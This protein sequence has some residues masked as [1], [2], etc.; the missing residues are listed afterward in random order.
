MLS[1]LSPISH[2]GYR[3]SAPFSEPRLVAR[4]LAEGP[5]RF[6][7]AAH[8]RRRSLPS[9]LQTTMPRLALPRL[10]ALQLASCPRLSKASSQTFIGPTAPPGETDHIPCFVTLLYHPCPPPVRSLWL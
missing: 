5:S 1:V 10:H 9:E 4:T 2:T 8:L 3:L 6:L 7:A